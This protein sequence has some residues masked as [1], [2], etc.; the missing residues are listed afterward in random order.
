QS[1]VWDLG[2][3]SSA[4]FRI[5][6]GFEGGSNRSKGT[7]PTGTG[8]FASLQ[9]VDWLAR[10]K[11]GVEGSVRLLN[12]GRPWPFQTLELRAAGVDR[13][14][15]LDELNYN[16]STDAIDRI[17]HGHKLYGQIDFKLII[18]QSNNANYGLKLTFQRGSLPPI[19][20]NT[21]AFQFGFLYET[22]DRTGN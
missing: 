17:A 14:L 7:A 15:F 11:A 6:G 20:A 5:V 19:F 13:Y 21:R 1:P 3:S 18:G 12:N 9:N 16:Q 10:A 4:K 22:K 8:P 2:P